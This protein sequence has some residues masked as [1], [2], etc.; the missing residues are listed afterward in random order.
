MVPVGRMSRVA[1]KGALQVP[2]AKI[3]DTAAPNPPASA[4]I[5]PFLRP[6]QRALCITQAE[7]ARSAAWAAH[8][9]FSQGGVWWVETHLT[10]DGQAW[11][12]LVTP[13]SRNSGSGEVSLAWLIER[14]IRGVE[15]TRSRTWKTRVVHSVEAALAFIESVEEVRPTFAG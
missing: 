8:K 2:T 15:V 5:L 9:A 4:T 14:T 7:R 11:L 10:H 6:L 12:G 1:P 13:S 3:T